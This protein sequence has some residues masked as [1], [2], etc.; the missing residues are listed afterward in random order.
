MA[1][2]AGPPAGRVT[3]TTAASPHETPSDVVV[4][5]LMDYLSRHQAWGWM[6]LVAGASAFKDVPGLVF[7]KVMGSGHKGGFTL[8]PSASHQGLICRFSRLDQALEFLRG[9][10]AANLRERARES[11]SGVLAVTSSRGSWDQQPWPVSQHL[12]A[13]D[14][15][16]SGDAASR[17]PLAILTRASIVPTK[18]MAF[19]RHAPAA[20]S[21]LHSA[22][23]CMLAMGLGEAPLV[24]QCTFSLWRDAQAMRDYATRGAH[25]TAAAAAHRHGFFSESLFVHMD[26]L[27]MDGVWQ[28]QALRHGPVLDA[29][30]AH[31]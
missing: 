3:M 27:Q 30:P 25:Q 20:Q 18:A 7:A 11:W 26:V 29:E 12:P 24:R 5:M 16:G 23:G 15:S 28:G 10:Q 4:V 9:K 1:V 8:R 31:A 2:A 19:W 21:D 13:H 14:P 6:R 17:R 22:T